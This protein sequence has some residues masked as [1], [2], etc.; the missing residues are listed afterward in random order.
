[1]HRQIIDVVV[2]AT[3]LC[4]KIYSDRL[5]G[6]TASNAATLEYLKDLVLDVQPG[7][8]GGHSLVWFYFIAAA[9]SDVQEQRTFFTDRLIDIYNNTG[10]ANISKG[11]TM[12]EQ[13]QARPPHQMW[14]HVLPM[15]ST[16]FV[17]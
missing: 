17:M 4:F 12:L 9:D 14:P 7:S 1:M 6:K 3:Q 15:I 8:A 2:K 13:L 10:C 16:T 5:H 11:L